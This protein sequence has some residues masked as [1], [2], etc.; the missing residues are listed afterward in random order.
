MAIK[1]ARAT[2]LVVA[3]SDVTSAPAWL[4]ES[5]SFACTYNGQKYDDSL[6]LL[7]FGLFNWLFRYFEGDVE[8]QVVA[9][10]VL[11]ESPSGASES[12]QTV[13]WTTSTYALFLEWS[14]IT[15]CCYSL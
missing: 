5:V 7:L 8:D 1:E 13:I 10:N 11:D 4:P 15:R 14:L 9:Q 3:R 2:L 12:G 6:L